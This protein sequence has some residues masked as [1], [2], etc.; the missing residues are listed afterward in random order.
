MYPQ[1]RPH[2]P[3]RWS[4]TEHATPPLWEACWQA[5]VPATEA[6]F[7]SKMVS[8]R[9]CH[10]AAVGSL[11]AS[12]CTRNRGRIRQQ[13]GLPQ[14][15]PRRRCGKLAG[16][17]MY[18][19]QRPYSPARW[20]PTEHATP[21][22]WEACWQANVPATEAAFASKMVSHRACHGAAV[23]SL[24]ASECTHTR[25]RIRQQAGLPQFAL[26]S[27]CGKL[28]G[29][30]M[31]QRRRPHSPASWS[32]TDHATAPLWEACWQANVPAT[33]AAFASKMVSHRSCHGAAVGNL[34]A[35]ECTNS[36]LTQRCHGRRE[37]RR[38]CPRPSPPPRAL[39]PW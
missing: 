26:R 37:N 18:P 24:L 5:N 35:S 12:E 39:P 13:D 32:P 23:G 36:R 7:A 8:H 28:A 4:P 19:Q 22:L 1:Q 10:G 11:L 25:G 17:R 33:E 6:A 9:A 15:M 30:R 2:S 34:L 20:S 29:K 3:A 14:S 27:H 38:R 31:R 21:P 16:K